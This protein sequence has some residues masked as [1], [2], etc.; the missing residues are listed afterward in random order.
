M[1]I[2]RTEVYFEG[3]VHGAVDIHRAMNPSIEFAF[4]HQDSFPLDAL[5]SGFLRPDSIIPDAIDVTRF[6]TSDDLPSLLDAM[7]RGVAFEDLEVR[8]LSF[9]PDG[10]YVLNRNI[11]R[12]IIEV[13][14]VIENSPPEWILL[15]NVIQKGRSIPV[16]IFLG[17]FGIHEPLLFVTIPTGIVVMGA[18]FALNK[19]IEAGLPKF[20]QGKLRASGVVKGRGNDL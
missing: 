8:N 13:P 3:E 15:K 20:I 1:R 4:F 6:F 12:S 7:L 14:I 19:A 9:V 5:R 18:A 2:I 10:I 17:Y 16:G 11:I